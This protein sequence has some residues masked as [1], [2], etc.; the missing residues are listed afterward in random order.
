MYA[1]NCIIDTP[2]KVI[3]PANSSA[4]S[5]SAFSLASRPANCSIASVLD[6]VLNCPIT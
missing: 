5:F 3:C 6:F 1:K 4:C 2:G